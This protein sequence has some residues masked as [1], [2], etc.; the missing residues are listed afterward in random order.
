MISTMFSHSKPLG[1]MIREILRLFDVIWQP[2][3]FQNKAKIT[4][5]QVFLAIYILCKS[6]FF[7][8]LYFDINIQSYIYISLIKGFKIQE[9]REKKKKKMSHRLYIFMYQ[10]MT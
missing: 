1:S 7:F 5:S 9:R 8:T 3:C 4:F 10:N 2:F 6:F